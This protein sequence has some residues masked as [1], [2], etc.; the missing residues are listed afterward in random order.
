M[1]YTHE[2]ERAF[3]RHVS[4]EHLV[5]AVIVT[6]NGGR[7]ILRAIAAALPQVDRLFIVDN[8]SSESTLAE[9]TS[10][11]ITMNE[12]I[13]VHRNPTNIGLAEALNVGVRLALHHN[14]AW[15]LTLDQD[16][17]LWPGAVDTMLEAVERFAFKS[18]V[19]LLAPQSLYREISGTDSGVA[20][21]T[22]RVR[23][24]KIIHSSG[25]LIR[26][27]VF[28][29]VGPYRAE[30]FIDQLDYEFCFRLR[31]AGY[32]ILL[33]EDAHMEHALGR[34]T[35]HYLF[36]RR[37]ICTN[38]PPVRRYYINRNRVAV[39]LQYRD[40]QYL[41]TQSKSCA[42]ES[43]KIVLF[44]KRKLLKLILSFVGICHGLLGRSGPYASV[45]QRD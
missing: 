13:H 25:N 23:E 28:A 44:E 3:A 20:D 45:G 16:S 1:E 36:R 33:V 29:E 14:P 2:S 43:V 5:I 9:L 41:G 12:K 10:P 40:W 17:V 11:L 24:L 31:G 7:A 34:S 37:F 35:T 6:Y 42:I 39:F 38:H 19:A 8:G 18:E 32:R 30:F 22:G 15:I 26:S 27:R 4:S 21:R